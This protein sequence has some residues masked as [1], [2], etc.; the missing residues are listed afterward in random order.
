M[1]E[2]LEWANESRAQWWHKTGSFLAKLMTSSNY[3][4]EWQHKYLE[5]Y[6]KVVVPFLGPYPPKVGSTLTR[7]GLPLEFS[8]NYQQHGNRPTV[9]VAFEPLDEAPSTDTATYDQSIVKEFIATLLKLDLKGFDP[10]LWDSISK[11]I[12]INETEKALLQENEID[13]TYVRTQAT[14]GFDF[15]GEGDISVKAYAFPGLKCKASGQSSQKIL[16][17][18]ILN[19]QKQV[20]CSEVFS[21]IDEYL[22]A[23]NS[24]NPYSFFSWDCI[25]PSKCRLKIYTCSASMT[26]AKLEETWS[27]GTRLQ[28]SSVNKGLQHLLRLFDCIGIKDGELEVKVEHDDRSDAHKVTPLMWNYEMRSD[29]PLPLTKIYLPVHGESDLRVVTGVAQFMKEIGMTDI[30]DS[31]LDTVQSYL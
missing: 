29:D 25:E 16:A 24:Y 8:V 7:S 6:A 19:L 17:Q 10:R 30:G 3:K 12:H 1:T 14:F 27:L 11:D 23:S 2:T 4:V 13:D 21:R 28:S 20:H 31:Y 5:F 9:R 15:V 18:T 22:Q 26:R